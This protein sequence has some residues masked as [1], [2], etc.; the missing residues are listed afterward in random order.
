MKM[1]LARWKIPSGMQSIPKQRVQN[2]Y[3]PIRRRTTCCCIFRAPSVR[4]NAW[5]NSPKNLG[6]PLQMKQRNDG[7]FIVIA[8]IKILK[9]QLLVQL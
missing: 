2:Y 3:F 4:V 8:I 5:T 1:A 7:A 6:V 9:R